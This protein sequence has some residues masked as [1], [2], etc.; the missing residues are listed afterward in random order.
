MQIRA[1][2]TRPALLSKE[3]WE[4]CKVICGRGGVNFWNRPEAPPRFHGDKEQSKEVR[5]RHTGGISCPAKFHVGSNLKLIEV[6][7]LEW[8]NYF[9]LTNV[10]RSA[11]RQTEKMLLNRRICSMEVNASLSGNVCWHSLCIEITKTLHPSQSCHKKH[12]HVRLVPQTRL[13]VQSTRTVMQPQKD[14]IMTQTHFSAAGESG[15]TSGERRDS[16]RTNDCDKP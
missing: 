3:R 16:I 5:W 15:R 9:V 14:T 1:T 7:S 11:L 4:E 2:V 12:I 6:D 8:P 10:G 13:F